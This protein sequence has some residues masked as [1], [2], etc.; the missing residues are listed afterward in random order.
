MMMMLL[1]ALYY[2]MLLKGYRNPL[3]RD[4]LWSLNPEDKCREVYPVFEKCWQ[5]EMNKCERYGQ[6][7]LFCLK[8]ALGGSQKLTCLHKGS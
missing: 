2:S 3:T 1:L 8:V 5:R 7:L 6:S 4:D